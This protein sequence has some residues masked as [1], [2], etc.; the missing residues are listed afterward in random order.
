MGMAPYSKPKYTKILFQKFKQIQ[1]ISGTDFK[2]LKNQKIII[3]FKSFFEDYRFDT[4]VGALQ[5][6]T[7]HLLVKL[8]KNLIKK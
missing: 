7:E 3:F 6:Y 5:R 4:I 8:F 1:N 2:R